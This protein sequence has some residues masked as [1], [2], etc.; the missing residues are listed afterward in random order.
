MN[1]ESKLKANIWIIII[2]AIVISFAFPTPGLF[3]KPYIGY[4]LMVLMFLSCLDV[5]IKKIIKS[6]KEY[7]EFLVILS[8]IHFCSPLLVLLIKPFVSSE[9]FLGLI[10]STVICSGM[11][12]IFLSKLYGGT[13]VKALVITSFSNLIS[14]ITIPLLVLLFAGASIKVDAVAMGIAIFKLVVIPIVAAEIIGKT[15]LKKPLN[16]YGSTISIALLFLIMIGIV[17]PVRNLIVSNI[18]LSL[19]LI[20][21]AF[22]LISI[23]FLL[24]Y[25]FGNDKKEKITYGIAASYKNFTLATVIALSLFNETVALPVVIYAVANNLFLIPLQLIFLKHKK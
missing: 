3:L 25:L 24:G 9:I 19:V 2:T 13:P 1:L 6:L 5:T 4:L 23:N 8:I 18:K 15:R 17:S 7:K 11:A 16:D 14:P 20:C 10:I 12:V 21:L 22:V